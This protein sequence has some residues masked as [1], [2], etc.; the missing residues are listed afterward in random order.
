MTLPETEEL[1]RALVER[2]PSF[3]G[4]FVVGVKTTGIFCRSVCPARKPLPENVEFF[5]CAR[6][7]LCA[8]YRPCRRCHP[9]DVHKKPPAWLVQLQHA[10][11]A[12]PRARVTDADLRSLAIEPSRVRRHFKEHYGMTFQAYQRARRLGL[13]LDDVRRGADLDDI[14][15]RH[16]F[17]SASGFREAFERAFG[18]PPGR[19]RSLSP[20]LARWIDTPL[21]AM[22]AVAKDAGLCLLE[23]VDRKA[24][25]T[26]IAGL[27]HGRSPGGGTV[28]PGDHPHLDRITSELERYFAGTLRLFETPLCF[29]GT[30]FQRTVW[31][32]LLR[33]PYAETTSY[34]ALATGIGRTGS[35]RAV[36]RANG[37]NRLALVVPCHRVIGA[38]GALRGYAGGVW[39]K[40]WLLDHERRQM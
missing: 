1:Y 2:D 27:A 7:A 22:L 10:L 17:E 23:F 13:A 37:Q 3:D 19:A 8:G 9:T 21:G 34:G 32:E 11:D 36:A 25:A 30:E 31:K 5:G 28:V 35:Q 15:Y 38:D 24:L 6:E 14:G 4:L 40:R 26:Q 20:M 33:I 39:R 18:C 29:I 12:S 16:G